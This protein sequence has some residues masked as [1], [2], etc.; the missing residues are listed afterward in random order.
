MQRLSDH[1]GAI[2]AGNFLQFVFQQEIP[3]VQAGQRVGIDQARIP[4]VLATVRGPG[5]GPLKH[6]SAKR[7]MT[8]ESAWRQFRLVPRLPAETD[9]DTEP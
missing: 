7:R 6:Q 8:I 1:A 9:L 4:N 3:E 2:S 5:E